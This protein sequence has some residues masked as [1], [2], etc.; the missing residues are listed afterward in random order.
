MAEKDVKTYVKK[1]YGEI[2]KG[3]GSCCPSCGCGA[4]PREVAL[5]IGYTEMIS[6]ICQKKRS[7]G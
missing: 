4:D 2:A 6:I 3:G 5:Q 1:R 7:W